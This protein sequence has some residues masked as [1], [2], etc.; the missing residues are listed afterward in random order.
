MLVFSTTATQIHCLKT[1]NP[2]KK[3]KMD[4]DVPFPGG[5]S[6]PSAT[7]GFSAASLGGSGPLPCHNA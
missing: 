3:K 7:E 5:G 6:G 1:V 4:K 2:C